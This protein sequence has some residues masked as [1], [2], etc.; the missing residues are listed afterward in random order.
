MEGIFYGVFTMSE[1][2]IFWFFCGMKNRSYFRV[3]ADRQLKQP[4]K[5]F[6]L[7]DF[8][9]LIKR[10]WKNEKITNEHIKVL[11]K[12]GNQQITPYSDIE[13]TPKEDFLWREATMAINKELER[14]GLAT[15]A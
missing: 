10:L 4:I 3:K 15:N 2:L 6:C 14:I 1:D 13:A 9:V 11:S 12:Y 8:A 5:D 7:N